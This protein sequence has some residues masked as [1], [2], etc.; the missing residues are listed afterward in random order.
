MNTI[1]IISLG[2]LVGMWFW[3]LMTILSTGSLEEHILELVEKGFEVTRNHQHIY[4][5]AYS[6][7]IV[8]VFD[9]KS[10]DYTPDCY[11]FRDAKRAIRLFM[12]LS[13]EN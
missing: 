5:D 7:Y 2:V 11:K 8:L 9:V 3:S 13:K 12:M 4:K 10:E 6:K 1:W